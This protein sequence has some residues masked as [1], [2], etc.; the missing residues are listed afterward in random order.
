MRH[1]VHIFNTLQYTLQSKIKGERGGEIVCTYIE[2]VCVGGAAPVSY[3][4][5]DVYKRQAVNI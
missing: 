1:G 3:T 2:C 4:H 5:L